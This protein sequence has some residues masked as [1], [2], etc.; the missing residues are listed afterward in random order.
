MPILDY[1]I[2]GKG[3]VVLFLH[4]WGQ[5]K[6]MML[7]IINKLKNNYTCIAIDMP[8]FGNSD[9]NNESNLDEYCKTISDFLLL[10][11]HVKPK[12]IIG[13]SFGGK[14]AINY[15]LKYKKIKGIVLIASPV[16]KPKRKLNY[17]FKVFI[18]KLKKKLKIKNNMGSLDY[19]NT[20]Q[21]MKQ[22]FVKIVNTHYN[23]QLKRINLPMLLLYSKDDEKVEFK[24]GKRLNKILKKSRLRVINGDHFAYLDNENIVSMEI[25]NF[26]KEN[27]KKREYYL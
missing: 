13:H 4:G 6:E 2:I 5:N 16:L 25:N 24:K 19:K 8:G 22:F 14:V 23:K 20:K 9:F 10:K 3:P 7:P 15:Y 21:E 26:I 12:Y 27:E 17:Y 11:L 18:Y 1:F